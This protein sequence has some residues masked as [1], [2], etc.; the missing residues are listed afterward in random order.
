MSGVRGWV[1]CLAELFLFTFVQELYSVQR[2]LY[3]HQSSPVKQVIQD[4]FLQCVQYEM[5]IKFLQRVQYET[6]IKLLQCVQYDT[7][8]KFLQ[9]VQYETLIKFL[10]YVQYEPSNGIWL[11]LIRVSRT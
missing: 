7:L 10:Q 8:M 1:P 11:Q 4:S 5:L 2:T 3:T 9:C 6:L